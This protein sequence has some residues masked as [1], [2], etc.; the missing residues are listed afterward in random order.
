MKSFAGTGHGEE[1][2]LPE[3]EEQINIQQVYEQHLRENER[4]LKEAE[5]LAR[6]GHWEL[7]IE[8]NKL[9]WSAETFRIFGLDPIEHEPSMD[10][11]LEMVHPDDREYVLQEYK[12]SVENR[13]QYNVY[14]RLILKSGETKFLNERCRTR[15]DYEGHP[16]R[17]FG[18]VLD[19][20]DHEREIGKL[21]TAESSL[22][23]YASGLE[24]EIEL[25]TKQLNA[26]RAELSKA[27]D[28]IEVLKDNIH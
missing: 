12:S 23:I 21:I 17:S 16:T 20:T 2:L 4:R 24:E 3:A 14:H 8:N 9:Y 7:D 19:M 15:Y 28:L 6:L 22:K 5:Q 25:L 18:T 26:E 13:T 1:E 11:F 10:A 27:L